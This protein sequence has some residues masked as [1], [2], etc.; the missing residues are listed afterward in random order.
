[1]TAHLN[2][3]H[4]VIPFPKEDKRLCEYCDGTG[5]WHKARLVE[6]ICT[7][8]LFVIDYRGGE[9]IVPLSQLRFSNKEKTGS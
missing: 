4:N 5:Y 9:R 6:E 7:W 1:M 8:G 3:I 2:P